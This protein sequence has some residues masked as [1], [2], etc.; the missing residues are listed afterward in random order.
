MFL[1]KKK[2]L[3]TFNGFIFLKFNIKNEYLYNQRNYELRIRNEEEKNNFQTRG[4]AS[5]PHSNYKLITL[6][7]DRQPISIYLKER[8]FTNHEIY[9]IKIVIYLLS[10]AQHE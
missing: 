9:K 6:K 8:P 7:A 4:H 10:M 2:V 5:L 1:L 3:F